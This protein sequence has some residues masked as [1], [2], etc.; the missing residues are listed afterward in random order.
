VGEI[1]LC[2]KVQ[3]LTLKIRRTGASVNY[4]YASLVVPGGQEP[5]M[6]LS[7]FG[8]VSPA[9]LRIYSPGCHLKAQLWKVCATLTHWVLVGSGFSQV[10]K[11]DLRSWL[12]SSTWF[13]STWVSKKAARV[14]KMCPSKMHS[15]FHNLVTEV[16][17]PRVVTFC[18]LAEITWRPQNQEL[19]TIGGHLRGCS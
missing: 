19:K 18:W 11:S 7:H 4:C 1:T 2:S 14:T 5:S 16:K 9:P 6:P 8:S 15:V 10:L 3:S 17:S 13:L 12:E